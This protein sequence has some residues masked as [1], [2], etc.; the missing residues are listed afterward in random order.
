M[1]TNLNISI[2]SAKVITKRAFI[3]NRKGSSTEKQTGTSDAEGGQT[4]T[5]AQNDNETSKAGT[6]VRR[7]KGFGF[8]ETI[9]EEEQKKAVKALEGYKIGEREI[10]VKIANERQPIEEQGKELA[11]KV[12]KTEGEAVAA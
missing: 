5:K 7:S 1:F 12:E 11:E 6:A 2:K 4:D 3:R 10:T 8:V 9:N